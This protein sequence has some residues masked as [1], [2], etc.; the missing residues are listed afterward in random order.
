[1]FQWY[2]IFICLIALHKNI[3]RQFFIFIFLSVLIFYV[4]VSLPSVGPSRRSKTQ[5]LGVHAITTL[6]VL[7]A[8]VVTT[9]PDEKG[10]QVGY[11]IFGVFKM[12]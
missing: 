11:V 1:M 5:I 6:Q 3:C 9:R 7:P 2:A 12:L 10:E 4:F 8:V